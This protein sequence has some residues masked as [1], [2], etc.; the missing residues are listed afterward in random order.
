MNKIKPSTK[1]SYNSKRRRM[2]A[3]QTRMLI[4][5]AARKLFSERGYTGA[6]MEAI[7]QESGVAVETV[8]AAFGNKR[9]ILFKL[10]DF[11]LVGDDKPIPLL[12]RTG[13]QSVKEEKNPQRQIELFAHDM[14]EIM[15]RIAPV[16]EVMRFAAKTEPEIN[17]LLHQILKS[18][19]GGMHVFLS[20]LTEHT[21][22]QE[23]LNPSEAAET[24]WAVTSPEMF[25]LLIND[26]GW[27][28]EQYEK[29]LAKTLT[30]LLL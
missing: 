2:Q 1:R 27:P 14:F 7:A 24:V 18:R 17:D 12:Q 30:K 29:W 28:R 23:G 11:L 10:I 9:E 8:Y 21:P 4:L 3:N 20:Y 19:L 13:P 5:E 22:L 26:R 6:T 15:N 25:N 16:F